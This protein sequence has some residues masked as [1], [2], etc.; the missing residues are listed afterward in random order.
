MIQGTLADADEASERDARLA[1][2]FAFLR[3]MTAELAV[4]K[5]DIAGGGFAIVSEYET[6]EP[7]DKKLEAH[8]KYI[9]IQYIA[10]GEEAIDVCPTAGLRVAVKYD[11][12]KDILF[13][14]DPDAIG[15]IILQSGSFAVFYPEDAHRPGLTMEEGP[16]PIRKIVVKI[17]V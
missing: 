1:P 3:G 2:G 13:F 14:H 4:G 5:H 16:A 7:E 9:D 15:G 11:E 6:T 10:K 12:S 8:R 17:P